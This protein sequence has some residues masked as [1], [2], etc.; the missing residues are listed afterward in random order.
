[1]GCVQESAATERLQK[2]KQSKLKPALL[3]MG[4]SSYESWVGGGRYA[5]PA[6]GNDQELGEGF[7]E[8]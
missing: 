1:M 4:L 7:T 6:Q 2:E 5:A 3:G 8:P